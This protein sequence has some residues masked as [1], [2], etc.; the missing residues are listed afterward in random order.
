MGSI[1]FSAAL[2]ARVQ[3]LT[4]RTDPSEFGRLHC[5]MLHIET[6]T[7]IRI[8][9]ESPDNNY[10]VSGSRSESKLF[11]CELGWGPVCDLGP[12]A[13]PRDDPT[14]QHYYDLGF[15]IAVQTAASIRFAVVLSP[16]R[17]PTGSL[18]PH[19]T[20]CWLLHE[21]EAGAGQPQY[22]LV[23]NSRYGPH[24]EPTYFLPTERE[25]HLPT[26]QTLCSVAL[27]HG[28]PFG[29]GGATIQAIEAGGLVI[30]AARRMPD[31]AMKADFGGI[32]L[33]DPKKGID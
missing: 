7:P 1:L 2:Q 11:E 3:S 29:E 27:L 32:S 14:G 6:P 28:D 10:G 4:K 17:D 33:T 9:L 26:T 15:V 24:E 22:A 8:R 18:F 23:Y 13:L 21:H 25:T 31:G 30:G 5:Q 12:D 19:F 16:L 20:L